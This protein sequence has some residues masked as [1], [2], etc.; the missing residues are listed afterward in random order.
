VA[1]R[2]VRR[3]SSRADIQCLVDDSA[4]KATVP[5]SLLAHFKPT[6]TGTLVVARAAA[7][8]ASAPNATVEMTAFTSEAATL[9]YAP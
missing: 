9:Q 5:R 1:A 8:T 4:G 7:T 6:D 3:P 2:A